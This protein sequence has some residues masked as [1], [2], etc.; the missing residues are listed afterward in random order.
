MKNVLLTV[1]VRVLFS[2]EIVAFALNKASIWEDSFANDTNAHEN[3]IYLLQRS[4]KY[5]QILE[6]LSNAE[7]YYT[8]IWKEEAYIQAL[9]GCDNR[10]ACLFPVMRASLIQSEAARSCEYRGSVFLQHEV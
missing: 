10:L 4:P 9:A 3:L 2:V 5:D 1:I 7:K 8:S 6:T